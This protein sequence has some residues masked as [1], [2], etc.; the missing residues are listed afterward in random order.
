MSDLRRPLFVL[1]SFCE[2]DRAIKSNYQ[3]TKFPGYAGTI[4]VQV[5]NVREK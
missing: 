2:A 1:R 4:T 3:R 5:D